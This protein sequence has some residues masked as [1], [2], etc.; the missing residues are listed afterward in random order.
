MTPGMLGDLWSFRNELR[1]VLIAFLMLLCLPVIA[2][3]IL[4][5]TGINVVSDKLVG[6]ST[7][8]GHV[9]IKDPLTGSVVKD[10]N[11]T[12][13][14][15]VHGI[16]TLE[17]GASDWPYQP[18]HT[19]ID[20]ANPDGRTGD[21]VHPFMDGSVFFAGEIFWGFGKYIMIDNGNNITS[22]YAHLDK[23]YVYPGE[24]VTIA[25]VIGLEGETG[26]STGPH[27]HFQINVY[28]I[29]VNPRTFILGNP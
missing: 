14:W 5:N 16:V 21:I 4:M 25:D 8:T 1:Y 18:F 9:Q 2:V 28:G 15:P 26:W 19:G 11:P 29:P 27:L 22:I 23:I 10:I 13:S 7:E 24:H 20:I 12:V 3:V 6:I 17:F